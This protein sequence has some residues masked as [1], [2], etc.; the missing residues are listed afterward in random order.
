MSTHRRSAPAAAHDVA[1]FGAVLRTTARDSGRLRGAAREGRRDGQG[2][3]MGR[4]AATKAR[5]V[6]GA[7]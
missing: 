5:S 7:A 3:D 1:R 2:E 4:E 6:R